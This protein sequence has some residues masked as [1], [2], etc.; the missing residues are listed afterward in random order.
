MKPTDNNHKA[1]INADGERVMRVSQVMKKLA[2]EQIII[3]ANVLGLKGISYDKELRRSANIGSLMHGVIEN[4]FKEGSLAIID[5]E[6]YDIG[7]DWISKVEATNAIK[8]FFKWYKG[9]K[10][11]FKVLHEEF[12]VV[13]KHLGGTIDCIIEDWE[14]PDKII[15]VDYKSGS[16]MQLSWFLQLSAYAMLY[17]EVYGKGKIGGVMVIR[18]DKKHGSRAEAKLMREE[19]LNMCKYMFKSLFNVACAEKMLND[20]FKEIIETVY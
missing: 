8:S 9:M 19:N 17:D 16:S 18:A 15:L 2:K 11:R 6:A 5:Y 12:V 1:Y 14:N 10:D 20:N 13:G 4:Y 7:Y 3:W